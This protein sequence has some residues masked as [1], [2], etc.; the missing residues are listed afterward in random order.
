[1]NGLLAPSF[2]EEWW[3]N[4]NTHGLEEYYCLLIWYRQGKVVQA[5]TTLTERQRANA[6]SFNALIARDRSLKEVCY[7]MGY[8]DPSGPTGEVYFYCFDDVRRGIAYGIGVNGDAYTTDKPSTLIIHAVGVPYTPFQGQVNVTRV[9]GSILYQNQ[10]EQDK[11]GALEKKL[12]SSQARS[13]R[14]H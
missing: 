4:D 1:M 13:H 14:K 5:E 11:A 7:Y 10:A 12:K 9:A 3:S 8:Y 2:T 6:P